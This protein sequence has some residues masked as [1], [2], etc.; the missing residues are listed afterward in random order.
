MYTYGRVTL[1][2]GKSPHNVVKELSSRQSK[3]IKKQKTTLPS[4]QSCCFPPS[5]SGLLLRAVPEYLAATPTCHQGCE[6]PWSE[7]EQ[8]VSRER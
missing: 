2:C 7:G 1:M 5:P 8:R 3:Q 6:E 4:A